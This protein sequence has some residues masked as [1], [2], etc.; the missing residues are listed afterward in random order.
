MLIWNSVALMSMIDILVIA[1]AGFAALTI[2][3]YRRH[4]ATLGLTLGVRLLLNALLLIAAF[5]V[6]DLAM[7]WLLPRFVGP[8]AAM[9][10]MRALHL[11]RSWP[12]AL[13][14][15]ALLAGGLSL[16]VR[17]LV[18]KAATSMDD[19]ERL[20]SRRTHELQEAVVE[21][22]ESEERTRQIVDTALDALITTDASGAITGW[23]AQATSMFG[24]SAGQARGRD[25]QVTIVAERDGGANKGESG[26]DLLASDSM[27]LDRQQELVAR[28]RDGSEFPSEVS[29]VQMQVGGTA[30]F[31]VAVRDISA[32]KRREGLLMDQEMQLLQGRKM[33]AVGQL[34][35]GVAHDFNNLLTGINGYVAFTLRDVDAGSRASEDLRKVLK[36]ADRASALTSQLLAFGRQQPLERKIMDLN[37]AVQTSYDLL[38]RLIGENI[39]IELLVSEDLPSIEADPSQIDQL[40][41]NLALN[42]RDAMPRGGRLTLATSEVRLDMESRAVRLEV[43]AGDYVML[44][45]ADTGCGM[46]PE[47]RRQV[48]EPF[49][50]TKPTGQGT[51]LGLSSAYGIVKQHGGGICVDSDPGV[52]SRFTAVFPPVP[53]QGDSDNAETVPVAAR[54]RRH[55]N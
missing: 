4:T 23:N 18:P 41:M 31:S 20:V 5:Y 43:P 44:T 34:A 50:T 12:G 32:R 21:L 15:V 33:E 54:S 16:M 35:A 27:F 25:L 29:V 40:I 39:E 11:G 48:F 55:D 10:M 49:F 51:G 30:G 37:N 3:K 45:V 36:M 6:V 28:R 2:H 46:E 24:W 1:A 8:D 22:A 53:A 47:V 17:V 7:M 38:R 19:L 14:V 52:G 42:A 26:P 9:Q 13:L